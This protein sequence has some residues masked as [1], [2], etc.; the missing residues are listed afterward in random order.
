MRLLVDSCLGGI[1]GSRREKEHRQAKRAVT[2]EVA[3]NPFEK[4]ALAGR[5][6]WPMR[7]MIPTTRHIGEKAK[8]RRERNENRNSNIPRVEPQVIHSMTMAEE[9]AGKKKEI[10][11]RSQPSQRTRR[12]SPPFSRL[13]HPQSL[14]LPVAWNWSEQGWYSSHEP[15]STAQAMMAFHDAYELHEKGRHP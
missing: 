4:V 10:P 13:H 1:S 2:N 8:E 5:P 7:T 12:S 15:P 14:H 11:R 3:S 6:I 9:K